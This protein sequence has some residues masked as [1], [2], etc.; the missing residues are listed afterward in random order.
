MESMTIR[1]SNTERDNLMMTR[2]VSA[3]VLLAF[4]TTGCSREQKGTTGDTDKKK[5]A[6]TDQKGKPGEADKKKAKT[7]DEQYADLKRLA[8]TG[9]ADAQYEMGNWHSENGPKPDLTQS[10]A[11]LKKAAAQNHAKAQFLLGNA[12]DK[13]K[14]VPQNV[15]EAK[16]WYE[17]AAQKG[18]TMAQHSLGLLLHP[19]SKSAVQNHAESFKWFQKAAANGYADSQFMLGIEYEFG[20]IVPKDAAEA[21]RWYEKAAAQGHEKAKQ[22][23][24][25]GGSSGAGTK[26]QEQT[27]ANL[28]VEAKKEAQKKKQVVFL[29]ATLPEAGDTVSL[30]TDGSKHIIMT[31]NPFSLSKSFWAD[32]LKAEEFTQAKNVKVGSAVYSSL[33]RWMIRCSDGDL[34]F[35]GDYYNDKDGERYVTKVLEFKRK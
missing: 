20:V 4:L 22:K 12:Y 10:V 1:S 27:Y 24:G 2:I 17:K 5:A 29:P 13:G 26:T 35:Y 23:V 32:R 16:G 33:H 11:W 30:L 28:V 31:I 15:N 8:E 7:P 19:T 25:Q 21:K 14:G 18:E 9:N 6:A 3:V 34:V